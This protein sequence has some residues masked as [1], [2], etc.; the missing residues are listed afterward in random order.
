MS[1]AYPS[2]NLSIY[3]TTSNNDRNT[4]RVLLNALV[5]SILKLDA[6]ISFENLNAR[7]GR[8]D[9]QESLLD[10]LM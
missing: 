5:R 10:T 9:L 7:F 2:V 8:I 3:L 4:F 6:S 1:S